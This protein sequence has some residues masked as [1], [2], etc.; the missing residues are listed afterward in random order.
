MDRRLIMTTASLF[1]S[2]APAHAGQVLQSMQGQS[3]QG[4]DSRTKRIQLS[5]GTQAMEFRC[6]LPERYGLPPPEPETARGPRP[7][8]PKGPPPPPP[9]ADLCLTQL[10]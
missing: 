10:D 5:S 4:L 6:K 7:S 9:P 2:L 3:M 1:L 8:S